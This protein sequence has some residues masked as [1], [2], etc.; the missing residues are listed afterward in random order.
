MNRRD[1]VGAAYEGHRMWSHITRSAE[2]ITALCGVT[3]S[4]H[5][6]YRRYSAHEYTGWNDPQGKRVERHAVCHAC[7]TT[8]AS[9]RED[10]N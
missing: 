6:R 4:P 1:I 3:T 8:A 7:R 9:G 10:P 2:A 5:E